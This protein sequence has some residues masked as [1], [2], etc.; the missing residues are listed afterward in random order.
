MRIL[1]VRFLNLNALVGEWAIDLTD[2]ALT[3]EGLFAITGPTGAGKTTILDAICLALY[4]RTPR[5]SKVNKSG[6]EIMSRQAGEC[7]A[8]VVF[9]AR[10]RRYRCHWQQHRARRR[11]QGELQQQKHEI[12][13]L[14]EGDGGERGRILT[15]KGKTVEAQIAEITGLDFDRFTRSAMLAQGAFAAF[16]NADDRERAA[17]LEELT[18]TGIYGEIST[19]VYQ[20]Q[21]DE[22]QKLAALR[23][24]VSAMEV[25]DE[26]ALLALA[27]ALKDGEAAL[28][29]LIEEHKAASRAEAWR[30]LID[31]L[32]REL[33][34]LAA[35][36]A[37]LATEAALFEPSRE[38]LRRAEKAAALETAFARM[39]AWRARKA[40]DEASRQEVEA[41]LPQLVDRLAA[42]ETEGVRADGRLAQVRTDEGAAMALIKAA[43]ALDQQVATWRVEV[44]SQRRE[45]DTVSREIAGA[46]REAQ[47]AKGRV[48]AM[49]ARLAAVDEFL[50]Q[51]ARDET[52]AGELTGLLARLGELTAREQARDEAAAARNR[53]GEALKRAE[54]D[55]RKAQAASLARERALQQAEAA[56]AKKER[57]LTAFLDGQ[58]LRCLRT[59]RDA[60]LR[61]M[62]LCQRIADLE[63]ERSQLE[64]GR[65]C[66]LCGAT[67]HPF[68]EGN[69]PKVSEVAEQVAA[70]DA[71]IERV[72]AMQQDAESQARAAQAARE[73]F[74]AA[75]AAQEKS[76]LTRQ[77]AQTAQAEAL[78]RLA[79]AESELTRRRE[80][81]ALA[82]EPWLSGVCRQADLGA[83]VD[84]LRV[85][86][87]AWASKVDERATCARQLGEL[88][89]EE[90]RLG[91]IVAMR[92]EAL[93]AAGEKLATVTSS[94]QA[95]ERERFEL[96]GRRDPDEEE[97]QWQARMRQAEADSRQALETRASCARQLESAE[98]EIAL[99][100]RQI[101][102]AGQEITAQSARL[103][104]ELAAHGFADEGDW[105]N[106]RMT[107]DERADLSRQEKALCER[108]ALNEAR[109]R[110]K[111]ARLVEEEAQALSDCDL[112]E[113]SASVARLESAVATGR[114]EVAI[115]RERLN[116]DK[117]ARAA[118]GER[119]KAVEAQQNEWRRWNDLCELIGSA[120]GDKFR[121]FAQGLTFD[122]VLGHANVELARL[123]D[124]YLL[125]R[126]DAD[127]LAIGVIDNYQAGVVRTA[128]NLSGGESFIVSLALALGLSRM[129]SRNVRVDSLFLD[130]G[131]G[132]LDEA[133]LDIALTALLGL[134]HEGKLIG[135][136]SHVAALKERV[137]AQI[138]VT[139]LSGGKSRLVGPG[140]R[141][142]LPSR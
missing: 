55:E 39:S 4:G 88:Q 30:R 104:T 118:L 112:E 83:L 130:E 137:S 81:I 103:T 119:Q 62:A 69:V 90:A 33:A 98:A 128:K 75:R 28:D 66:P 139:P 100:R 15:E 86:A 2:E 16:L 64:D 87:R 61:E 125:Q 74:A 77:G 84:S 122:L 134:R 91:A 34:D 111:E 29:K 27:Q 92:E 35:E 85:R 57:A 95:R 80:A 114:G 59:D 31:G 109:G 141:A 82:L 12:A 60:R 53:A 47:A 138:R 135:V 6:N 93:R 43:R 52:L 3:R 54:E 72:E 20:R 58:T 132:A 44:A 73:A 45:V 126:L 142:I 115:L 89:G 25:L 37:S 129:A 21:S 131:F 40:K 11:A 68:A 1:S 140:C 101:D 14:D 67:E 96:Y 121:T 116:A 48:A 106:A 113:L 36:K 41:R 79:Q 23:A 127:S 18:H 10:G 51:N 70:L 17:I 71:R 19:A 22:A 26:A 42:A 9:E 32:R 38:R 76:A 99:L 46:R 94:L 117:A 63:A 97:R 124:R 133:A 110:E 49:A 65:A 50:A 102:E 108:A 105:Q 136:I 7:F 56:L 24:A 8:E 120:S 78:A 107:A 13:I 5:L 123:T